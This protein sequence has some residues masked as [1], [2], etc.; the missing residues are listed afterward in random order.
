VEP[1]TK[2]KL[3]SAALFAPEV[4]RDPFPLYRE[5]RP[6]SPL[7]TDDDLWLVMQSEH[8][9]S[10]LS[11]HR[12]FSSQLLHLDNP[13]LRETPILFEDPPGHTRHRKLTQPAFTTARIDALEPWVAEVVEGVVAAIP[14][15][16]V[17]AVKALCDPLP[18]R[19]IAQLMGVPPE[20]HAQFK[21]WSDQRTYL[22]ARRTWPE[23]G[24]EARRIGE[25]EQGNRRLL[26]YFVEQA[27][28]RRIEPMDDLI[29]DMVAA[30][31]GD[32]ALG[33]DEIA[34]ICALLLTAGNVTTTNLLGNML[35]LLADNPAVYERLRGDRTL[36]P[37]A[38][39]EV[40]RLESPVQWLYRRATQ[41]VRLGDALIPAGASVIVYFGAANR[42]PSVYADPD[43]FRIDRPPS[44]HAA[45]GHGI[46]FCLGTPL[47][48][49]ETT[50]ALDTLLD[51]FVG[52]SRGSEPSV[53]IADAATHCGYR[54][55]PIDFHRS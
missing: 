4:V 52:L 54:Y 28:T 17:D 47:A 22:V 5:L 53:R 9:F 14:A 24:D 38:V 19:V 39:E 30:N 48:R 32:D 13:V 29:A 45:F 40:L 2:R 41:D 36:V 20:Q 49:L 1:T 23:L 16:E 10:V 21:Q 12:T 46:H 33:E 18:I 7:K 35:G 42:D 11:N 50:L 55:L 6:A 15:G 31:V 37:G 34:A 3:D 8:V 25:A 26:D 44:R 27:R 43:S 51:R